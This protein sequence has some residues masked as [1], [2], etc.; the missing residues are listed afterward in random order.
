MFRGRSLTNIYPP[1]PTLFLLPW[2]SVSP[3]G[4]GEGLKSD[5]LR[6]PSHSDVLSL[7]ENGTGLGRGQSG[8]VAMVTG[9]EG[10]PG[11]SGLASCPEA[12]LVTLDTKAE[13][14][15]GY[16]GAG[17]VEF[18]LAIHWSCGRHFCSTG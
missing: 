1:L 15:G 14:G 17:R 10:Y 3:L 11:L 4:T 8:H 9:T 13:G 5:D 18:E 12:A 7:G 16:G 2:A 6:G